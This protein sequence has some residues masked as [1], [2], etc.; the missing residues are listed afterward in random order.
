M[1]DLMR[2][3]SPPQPPDPMETG[4]AQAA[5]NTATATTQ[6]LINMVDQYTPEGQLTYSRI[7]EEQVPDGLGGI[8]TVPRFRADQQLS[9]GQQEI[10]DIGQ[11]TERN[12]A[13]IGR[14][15]SARIGDLLG[16]P[17]SLDN[18]AVESRL[19]DLGSRRLDPVFAQQ[20][21]NLRTRLA[22]QGIRPGSAAFDSEMRQFGEGRN[23][24]Y[25]NLL[26]SGRGQSVQE[27]LAERNQPI[28]EISALLSQSQVSQ[29]QF[30]N[31][32]Q[33]GVGGVDYSGI[34]RDNYNQ[35]LTAWQQQQQGNNAM[36][37]GLFG[38]GSSAIGLFSDIRLK[39]NIRR[40]GT[41]PL[42]IGVYAYDIF[43]RREI[44][45]MAQE[46]AAV[47][48]DAVVPHSSGFLTVNYDMIGG[49]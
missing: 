40:I 25:N 10:F 34:V 18:E 29:P 45:V 23:D 26:L 44:G 24:A 47:M 46:L 28:N 1:E 2:A 5:S 31:T 43:D 36:M 49:V 21:E 13:G 20:E 37:G 41:H 9:P 7:G 6:S 4:R 35:Q 17:V 3:P 33:T 12:I 22:N 16:Q 27:I 19:F 8:L 39:S 11:Q 38:L 30:V 15:Q 32:P 42:G 48:P 14:D